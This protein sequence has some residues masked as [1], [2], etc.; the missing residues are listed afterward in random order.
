M[1]IWIK[2]DL[3]KYIY[4][5]CIFPPNLNITP[6]TPPYTWA[7]CCHILSA[8]ISEVLQRTL[9]NKCIVAKKYF[10]VLRIGTTCG[11]KNSQDMLKLIYNLIILIYNF[12]NSDTCTLIFCSECS[13]HAYVMLA[14]VKNI[15]LSCKE[16][17]CCFTAHAKTMTSW[18]ALCVCLCV[19][20]A[21]VCFMWVYSCH[22]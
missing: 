18:H 6:Y 3:S 12:I 16:T 21:N 9:P 17:I 19:M 2:F 5:F 11:L 13:V 14:H 8:A 22:S 20:L 15:T 10:L 4:Y 7:F 1:F